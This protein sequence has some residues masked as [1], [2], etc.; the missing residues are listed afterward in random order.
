MEKKNPRK[1]L[2]ISLVLIIVLLAAFGGWW[3]LHS[4]E[5]AAQDPP[6]NSTFVFI[7][8]PASGEEVYAGDYVPIEVKATS[9]TLISSTYLLVDGE[10]LG[11]TAESPQLAYWSWQALPAGVHSLVARV[12]TIDGQ[13]STSQTVL[14]NVLQGDGIIEGVA[15]EGA[16]IGQTGSKYGATAEEMK[17]T[18][19]KIPPDIPLKDGQPIKVPI[20]TKNSPETIPSTGNVSEKGGFNFPVILWEYIP[21]KPADKSYCYI[22]SGNGNWT[23]IPKKP[24]TYFLGDTM[25][26][27]QLE[28]VAAT[29]KTDIEVNCWGWVGEVLKYLGSGKVKYDPTLPHAPLN[30]SGDSFELFGLPKIPAEAENFLEETKKKIPAPFA[31]REPADAKDCTKHHGNLLSGFVCDALMKA[32]VKQYY[33]LEWEWKPQINWP[34]N[35]KWV[36]EIDGYHVFEI[37]PMTKSEKLIA[38]INNTNQRV[39]AVP[40]PWGYVCYGVRA[41]VNNSVIEPSAMSSYCP[42]EQ[43]VTQKMSFSSTDW[44]TTGGEWQ[45][46]GGDED[47]GGA[48]HYDILKNDFPQFGQKS[49]EVLVGAS[50]VDDDGVYVEENYAGGIRFDMTLPPTAVLQKALLKFPNL[51]MDY[52]AT[53]L[54]APKPSSCVATIGKAIQAWDGAIYPDHVTDDFSLT[55]L[56]KNIPMISVSPY[57]TS[58]L[59]VTVIVD[60]WLTNPGK[61]Y[62]LVLMPA[63]APY[64][65]EDGSG[66]CISALHTITLDIYYFASP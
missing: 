32:N 48:S 50:I 34:A 25:K 30:I 16:T 8:S 12:L 2:I 54:A 61:N 42:G 41:F 47:T 55:S 21:L 57:M 26:Y 49:G 4:N 31:L 20:N 9:S 3:L 10:S 6:V 5:T 45:S 27:T 38:T 51:Y 63:S 60:S 23:K 58:E 33:V 18:N 7:T 24:F 15:Q 19:P 29:Q 39:S 17:K 40:L 46:V 65:E 64:P 35:E 1:F 53:A 59:D 14:I 43:P 66:R 36:N 62:G 56:N 28:E 52:G 13:V 22:S 37:D 11:S 44:L